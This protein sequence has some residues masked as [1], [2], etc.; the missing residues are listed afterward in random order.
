MAA[1]PFGRRPAAPDCN[2]HS[3]ARFPKVLM[4]M[5]NLRQ[6]VRVFIPVAYIFRELSVSKWPA[7]KPRNIRE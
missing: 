5:F 2:A 6:K 4:A 1:K 7:L 3:V